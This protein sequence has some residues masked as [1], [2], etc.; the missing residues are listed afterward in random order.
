MGSDFGKFSGGNLVVSETQIL[1]LNKPFLGFF[2]LRGF[3]GLNF[4]LGFPGA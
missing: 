1:G 4:F 2:N 3:G